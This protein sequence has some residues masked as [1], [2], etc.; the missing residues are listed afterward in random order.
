VSQG[1]PSDKAREVAEEKSEEIAAALRDLDILPSENIDPDPIYD[2]SDVWILVDIQLPEEEVCLTIK[3]YDNESLRLFHCDPIADWI[4]NQNELVESTADYIRNCLAPVDTTL[5]DVE[6]HE[7]YDEIDVETQAFSDESDVIISKG[8]REIEL[9]STP[10]AIIAVEKVGERID[11]VATYDPERHCLVLN[12]LSWRF[13]VECLVWP[14]VVVVVSE[15]PQP[16]FRAG[17]TAPPKR[18]KAVD[19]HSHS[20]EPFFDVVP[21]SVVEPTAQIVA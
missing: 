9:F 12:D 7:E 18:V 1:E 21:D 19:S 6:Y 15:A 17:L 16:L 2:S 8:A 10:S 20:L 14:F 13:A 3:M 11:Y 5:E 4:P